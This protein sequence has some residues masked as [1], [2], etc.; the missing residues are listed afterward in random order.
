[1]SASGSCA[2]VRTVHGPYV[3]KCGYV[4]IVQSNDVIRSR[5]ETMCEDSTPFLAEIKDRP[6]R[7]VA[8]TLR[9]YQKT[10]QEV[11]VPLWPQYRVSWRNETWPDTQWLVVSHYERRFMQLVDAVQK[12]NVRLRT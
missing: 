8:F 12:D 11:A 10:S 6:R 1:M 3:C 2:Y 9:T 4:P 7:S 5:V